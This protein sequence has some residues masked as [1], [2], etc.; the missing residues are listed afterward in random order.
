MIESHIHGFLTHFPV[1]LLLLGVVL[2]SWAR[3]WSEVHRPMASL[4]STGGAILV[5]PAIVSGWISLGTT[6]LNS[7][8]SA[9]HQGMALV[10]VFLSIGYAGYTVGLRHGAWGSSCLL[11]RSF[12]ALIVSFVVLIGLS[13]SLIRAEIA[14]ARFSASLVDETHGP[15]PGGW[16][17]SPAYAT[18]AP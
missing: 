6:S 5:V 8:L 4:A 18:L 11:R 14:Q 2:D 15:R 12:K 13:G 17:G 7:P 10:L 1:V 3:R 9:L 16:S